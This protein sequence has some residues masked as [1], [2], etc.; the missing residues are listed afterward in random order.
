[1]RQLRPARRARVHAAAA[2]AVL[3]A[4]I[5]ARSAGAQGPATSGDRR[6]GRAAFDTVA[7]G[8][9][10][11]ARLTLRAGLL[12]V[13]DTSVQTGARALVLPLGLVAEADSA[14]RAR[15][16]D[17]RHRG[18]TLYLLLLAVGAR[19]AG[20]EGGARCP[21]ATTLVWLAVAPGP[22]LAASR[23]VP[24]QSCLDL[25]RSVATPDLSPPPAFEGDVLRVGFEIGPPWRP[26]WVVYD[27]RR[28]ERGLTGNY[29]QP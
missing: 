18:G 1:M 26:R 20:P 24:L 17:A 9:G 25:V 8:A 27:R 11:G 23:A 3:A 14:V 22:T 5:G 4:A 7:G 2:A 29:A 12:Q 10:G 15:V 28:P 19:R 16:L 21:D 13:L 6:W